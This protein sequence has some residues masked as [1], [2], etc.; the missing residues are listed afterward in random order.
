MFGNAHVISGPVRTHDR[1]LGVLRR[2]VRK[3]CGKVSLAASLAERLFVQ[4]REHKHWSYQLH[5]D[6]LAALVK[7]DS[8]LGPLP[9]YSTVRRYMKT[10]GL[11]R[12]RRA[13]PKGRPGEARAA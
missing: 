3:D 13:V 7:A 12:T 2:A 11:V 6:N 9:S 4:Y 10:H 5:Y 8:T 1:R